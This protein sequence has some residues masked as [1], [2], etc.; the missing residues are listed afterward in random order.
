MEVCVRGRG[1][2]VCNGRVCVRSGS[3]CDGW[4]CV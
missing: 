4:E 2:G 1:V 3:V